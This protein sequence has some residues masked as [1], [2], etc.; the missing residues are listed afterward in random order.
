MSDE[1]S[2]VASD[3]MKL[4]ESDCA[5]VLIGSAARRRRTD[6][7]DIDILFISAEKLASVPAIPGYHIRF[8]TE[9]DF[10]R[11][12]AAGEDFEAWCVRLGVTLVD[13]GVWSRVKAA[14]G[15]VWPRWEVKV[16]HGIRRL[17]L[18]SQLSEL[19]DLFA[20]KE[21]LVFVLGH[22]A[23]ALLLKTGTFPLSRPELADQVRS[24]GHVHLADLH[25]R[26]RTLDTPSPK[27][28]SRGLLYSKKLL[29]HLDRTT[30]GKIA[31]DYSKAARAKE[32]K[33]EQLKGSLNGTVR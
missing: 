14:A 11:R 31:R 29:V 6:Q 33:R 22:I 13:R 15:D 7:S 16:V 23:R 8:G 32:L 10:M 5:A 19:G 25:E 28:V 3:L 17:F 18:A 1:F 30:Y 21:E 12:L 26:M 27:D 4:T 20:A 2:K 9:A 24:L